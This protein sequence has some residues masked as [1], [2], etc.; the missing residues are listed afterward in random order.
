MRRFGV[1]ARP[2]DPLCLGPGLHVAGLLGGRVTVAAAH[3][4]TEYTKQQVTKV[5][6]SAPPT[7]KENGP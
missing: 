5:L 3:E 7:N 1:L 2:L 6:P 4:A